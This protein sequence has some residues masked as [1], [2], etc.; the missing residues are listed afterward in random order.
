MSHTNT[1][2]DSRTPM[3]KVNGVSKRFGSHEVLK[4][5]SFDVF[6]GGVVVL[7]GP[8]GSG[9][10]TLLRC[11]NFLE[12]F[13]AGDIYVENQLVGYKEAYTEANTHQRHKQTDAQIAALRTKAGMVFQSFNLFP[14]KTALENVMM[15]PVHVN[16]ESKKQAREHALELLTKVG[17]KEKADHYPS[18]LS[19]GQQQR[20]AIARALAM[21]PNVL[22]LD[23]ITSALDPELVDEVLKT[24]RELAKEGM[25]MVLVTH[26][27]QFARDV[28]DRLLFFYEG[29]IMEDGHPS[30]VFANPKTERFKTFVS[31]FQNVNINN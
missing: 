9:K 8:S 24:L 18:Q 2:S 27:I 12:E 6:D 25:T 7:V 14:H 17:L 22:L 4:K 28:A 3:I 16:H 5:I 29:V 23:E 10:S 19:G 21:R 13:Q 31:R 11:I 26:E 20:V 30:E 1:H 15:G